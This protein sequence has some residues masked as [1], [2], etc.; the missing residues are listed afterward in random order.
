MKKMKRI[1]L[2]VIGIIGLLCITFG[3]IDYKR[4]R[5]GDRPLFMIRISDDSEYFQHYVGLGYRLVREVNVSYRE[6]LYLDDEIRFGL[7]TFT[8]KLTNYSC[9]DYVYTIKTNETNKCNKTT[10]LYYSEDSRNIYTY[11]LDSISTSNGNDFKD[12]LKN[13]NIKLDTFIEGL[14]FVEEDI[15]GQYKI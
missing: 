11:C 8:W 5:S 15:N 13:N 6:P 3:I 1:F 14:I 7:W 4:V 12:Y 10:Q 9:I 2:V